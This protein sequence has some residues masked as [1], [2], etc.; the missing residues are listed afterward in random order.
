MGYLLF[1]QA[2]PTPAIANYVAIFTII[3]TRH[4]PL[5]APDLAVAP[6]RGNRR[7]RLALNMVSNNTIVN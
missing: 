3:P 5:D 1:S 7:P 4:C 6:S 2:P